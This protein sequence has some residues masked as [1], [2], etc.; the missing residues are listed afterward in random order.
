MPPEETYSSTPAA[1]IFKGHGFFFGY[2][3]YEYW[4]VE[5]IFAKEYDLGIQIEIPSF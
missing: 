4:D 3:K 2:F 5:S 1:L